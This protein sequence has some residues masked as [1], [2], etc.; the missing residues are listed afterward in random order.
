MHRFLAILSLLR[1]KPLTGDKDGE[2][3]DLEMVLK[4][5]SGEHILVTALYNIII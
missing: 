4:L 3:G 5:L 2:E 1:P